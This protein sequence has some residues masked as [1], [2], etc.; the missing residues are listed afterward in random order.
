MSWDYDRFFTICCV[1]YSC[2]TYYS[3]YQSRY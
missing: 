3:N 1:R 2:K